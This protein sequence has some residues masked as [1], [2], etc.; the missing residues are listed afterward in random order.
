MALGDPSDHMLATNSSTNPSAPSPFKGTASHYRSASHLTLH[1][2]SATTRRALQPAN[3]PHFLENDSA[4]LPA[5]PKHAISS[6]SPQRSSSA[7]PVAKSHV[8]PLRQQQ[9]GQP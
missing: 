8:H 5:L 4:R 1:R 2:E 9:I 3:H 6:G 7:H